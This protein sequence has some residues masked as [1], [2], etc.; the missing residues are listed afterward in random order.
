MSQNNRKIINFL[1]KSNIWRIYILMVAIIIIGMSLI[2]IYI[3]KMTYCS[4]TIIVLILTAPENEIKRDALRNTYMEIK[5]VYHKKY[6]KIIYL[7][8]YFI[9]GDENLPKNVTEKLILEQST[10]KDIIFVPVKDNYD[11]LTLK[12]MEAFCYLHNRLSFYFDFNYIMK[13]DDDIFVNV[14]ELGQELIQIEAKYLKLKLNSYK[15]LNTKYLSVNLQSN[16]RNIG[17]NYKLYWGFMIG[18]SQIYKNGK[19]KES[20]WILCDYY[21]PYALGGGY[22]LSKAIINFFVKNK[23]DLS[24]RSSVS[25][26]DSA[27]VKHNNQV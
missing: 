10:Q 3:W 17:E 9:I 18:N 22:I 11:N 16:G 6:E 25:F 24:F 2:P 4:N 14:E 21:I 20:N 26:S 1:T 15:K 19:Y 13:F 7:K 27:S 23:N 12:M 8:Y 5:K